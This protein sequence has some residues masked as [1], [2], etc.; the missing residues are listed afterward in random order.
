MYPACRAMN[1]E[2]QQDQAAAAGPA[3]PH[4]LNVEGH[5]LD[6]ARSH[7][8]T[9]WRPFFQSERVRRVSVRAERKGPSL[10]SCLEKFLFHSDKNT[11]IQ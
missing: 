3:G 2:Q 4:S 7:G 11:F 6:A 1:G 5:L 10:Q 8:Q 9:Q